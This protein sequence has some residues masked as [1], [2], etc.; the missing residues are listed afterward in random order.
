MKG[1]FLRVLS[2][3]LHVCVHAKSLQ[4]CP[5]LCD[6][7]DC[8]P[9]GSSVH[10]IFQARILEWVAITSSRGSSRIKPASL[11]P[12]A[13]SGELFTTRPPGKPFTLF[14][15]P[16][17]RE[18]P[19]LEGQNLSPSQSSPFSR[20]FFPSFRFLAASSGG[21]SNMFSLEPHNFG[22]ELH[23]WC[24]CVSCSIQRGIRVSFWM[25]CHPSLS[26]V[27]FRLAQKFWEL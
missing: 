4:S 25:A 24:A 17:S 21:N 8:S 12:L 14:R 15:S 16:C 26:P 20:F 5:T 7:M 1:F 9:P 11:M 3:F 18:L 19:C 6:P 27:R 10:G 23:Q 13:L 2:F 22:R